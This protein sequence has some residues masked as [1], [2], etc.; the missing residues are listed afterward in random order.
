MSKKLTKVRF[1]WDDKS[2]L[3]YLGI[4]AEK[5]DKMLGSVKDS[6]RTHGVKPKW[7]E[8]KGICG[9][10]IEIVEKVLK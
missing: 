8:L 10:I 6:A 3:E 9:N 5:W 2:F 4:E 1:E 7:E